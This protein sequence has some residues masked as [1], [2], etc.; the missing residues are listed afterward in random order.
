MLL[1]QTLA[2][3]LGGQEVGTMEALDVRSPSGTT[4][5]R[6]TKLSVQRG[7]TKN[8]MTTETVVKLAPNG[9][10]VSY[11]YSRTDK[12]GTLITEGR[13][14]GAQLELVSTQNG[15]NVKNSV[16]VPAGST[17]ALA[18]EHETRTR[19]KDGL[20]LDR[21]VVREEMGA[22]VPMKVTVKKK[23]AG[24]VI[25]STFANLTTDEE[26]DVTGRTIVA[27]TPAVGIVA[28]P[29]G[30][31]PAD[32]GTGTADLLALSTWVT[33]DVGTPAARVLYRVTTS[34]AASFSVPEDDRQR[35][36]KRTATTIDIEVKT[37]P[38]S[39]ATLD[40]ERK[41]KALA[42]T[43]YEAVDD[44]RIKRAAAEVTKGAK[45]KREEVARLVRFV[46]DHVDAKG[47]DRGYAPAVA[48][49]ESKAG[50][51]TEHSVLLSAL[52][53][54]RGIPTR[55]VDGVVV[56]QT[57]AGYHEW[58]E[59]WLEGEGFVA[60]D[61]TFGVFPAGPERL[62]LAEGSTAPDEHLLLSLAAARLLKP[63]TRV[64]VLETSP[65]R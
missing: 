40:G 22:P 59:V 15:A 45:D 3:T 10:P 13:I 55:L 38:S 8:D 12:S 26:V 4:L 17:F 9:T 49:L 30:R 33:K 25:S 53:R 61:P 27:R 19:L 48:T 24:F 47:L 41:K 36:T 62:K 43:P 64:D 14:V 52:L 5:S 16:P 39:S 21:S 44:P 18:L 46:F 57:R 63:G 7:A 31:A 32:L 20:A 23:G 56:D 65:L 58:V 6:I 34:D 1:Q 28:Y 50:D 2:V 35:V 60:A 54:A 51:C 11:R 42:A 37:G 29:V